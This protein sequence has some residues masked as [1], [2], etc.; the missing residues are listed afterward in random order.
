MSESLVIPI[1]NYSDCSLPCDWEEQITNTDYDE[2][3]IREVMSRGELSREKA[4]YALFKSDGNEEKAIDYWSC[5]KYNLKYPEPEKGIESII[6]IPSM[7]ECGVFYT[8]ARPVVLTT[9]AKEYYGVSKIEDM[10]GK[11]V[12]VFRRVKD[13]LGNYET[14]HVYHLQKGTIDKIDFPWRFDMATVVVRTGKKLS[15]PI[16]I[17]RICI[18]W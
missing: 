9:N 2:G 10:V 4:I 14:P 8:T 7:D 12:G 5:I 15:S 6:S 3:S 13:E 18:D 16:K 1:Y 17:E 11:E